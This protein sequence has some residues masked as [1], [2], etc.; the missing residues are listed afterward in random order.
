MKNVRLIAWSLVGLALAAMAVLAFVKPDGVA[1][2]GKN[3]SSDG[4]T[5]GVAL[6]GPYELTAHT[7][8][9]MKSSD[10][11]GK[12]QLIFFGY[13]YCP[14]ICPME[15]QKMTVALNT[16]EESGVS[17]DAIQ[18]IFVSVDPERDTPESMAEYVPL[19]HKNL[20]GLSGSLEETREIAKSFRIYYAKREDEVSAD[21]LMDHSSM[22]FLMDKQGNFKRFF[23]SKDTP[24]DMAAYL[25]QLL[26]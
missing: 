5:V 6:G 9:R 17:T 20:I 3:M 19:F 14:D 24:E 11:A 4:T 25:K 1:P 21:Y 2:S 12:F 8:E 7:G 22:T 16:L 18:P 13:T 10:F 23:S 26:S 15:L